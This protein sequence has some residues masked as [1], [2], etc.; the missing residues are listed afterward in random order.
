M[1][2]SSSR[3]DSDP[4]RSG[5]EWEKPRLTSGSLFVLGAINL[6]D[7]INVSLLTP[8]VDRMVSDF[9][10]RPT[11]DAHVIQTVGILIGMYSLIEVVVSPFWGY[12][13]DI[14]GR[15]PVMLIGLAG[16]AFAPVLFG[17]ADTLPG[18]FFARGLDGFF[19]G[20]LG[21]TKAYM[22]EL[23]DST[24][25]ARGFSVLSLSFS[26]GLVIGPVLGGQL[27]YPATWLPGVFE[28]TTF[29]SHPYLLP[30]LI[31][32]CFAV[33]SW[34]CGFCFLKETLPPERRCCK[35][36]HQ[37]AGGFLPKDMVESQ[38]SSAEVVGE[39]DRPEGWQRTKVALLFLVA[40]CLLTGYSSVWYQ[41]FV[42]IVALPRSISG[43]ELEPQAIG[44]ILNAA[45]VGLILTQLLCYT[46]AT[47]RW[48]FLPCYIAGLSANLIVT[49]FFPVYGLMADPDKFGMWRLAPLAAMIMIGQMGFG[50]VFPSLFIWINRS[51]EGKDKGLWNGAIN[52]MGALC[53]GLFPPIADAL[54]AAGLTY[55]LPLG[56]YIPVFL[57]TLVGVALLALTRWSVFELERIPVSMLTVSLQ[58]AA[59][60]PETTI[61][62]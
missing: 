49:A 12:L 5:Q 39:Q 47:L 11:S 23:V 1:L 22:G 4:T 45:G 28:G 15:R 53:R 8:Y 20:N 3:R 33:I 30:N 44:M 6:I 25:E 59:Y 21:V 17:M 37:P 55:G 19:C 32:A 7:C 34:I 26:M 9:V 2:S 54:L 18:V 38:Q 14:L 16:S 27:V 61:A 52:S 42:L 51:L 62:S 46:R 57:M 36:R 43:F 35:R 40:Y 10:G 60:K 48:G 58:P 31:Y 13:A 50:F 24:N 56:R 41:I 29:D